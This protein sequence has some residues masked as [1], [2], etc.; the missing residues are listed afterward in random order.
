MI[1]LLFNKIS[2]SS[3]RAV[4]LDELFQSHLW[5][6][7][8][9]FRCDTLYCCDTI[10]GAVGT[11]GVSPKITTTRAIREENFLFGDTPAEDERRSGI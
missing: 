6:F 1:L 2:N 11:V 4:V 10:T 7:N 3:L 8:A 9:H 5:T